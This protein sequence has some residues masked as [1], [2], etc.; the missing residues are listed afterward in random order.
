M[1]HLTIEL[2]HSYCRSI[3]SFEVVDW[4]DDRVNLCCWTKDEIHLLC[5]ENLRLKTELLEARAFNKSIPQK[6]F[7]KGYETGYK[8]AIR[9]IMQDLNVPWCLDTEKGCK[10][11]DEVRLYATKNHYLKN[12]TATESSSFASSLNRFQR[13]GMMRWKDFIV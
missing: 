4:L 10:T 6:N 11:P 1:Q 2:L 5:N 7:T 8:W 12:A 13:S 9:S 3:A